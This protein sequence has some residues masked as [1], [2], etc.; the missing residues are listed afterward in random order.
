MP[1]YKTHNP[2]PLSNS[3]APVIDNRKSH[4]EVQLSPDFVVGNLHKQGMSVIAKADLEW[5][6]GKKS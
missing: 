1:D 6:G 5:A 2:Y 4:G 3:F